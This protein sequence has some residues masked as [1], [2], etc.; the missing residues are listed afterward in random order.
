MKRNLGVKNKMKKNKKLILLI[1][2]VILISGLIYWR[3][4]SVRKQQQKDIRTVTIKR[5]TLKEE[6]T[7]TG[8]IEALKSVDVKSEVSGKIISLKVDE[9][10]YV[11]KGDLIAQLD[12]T[13]AQLDYRKAESNYLTAKA[14]LER[15]KVLFEKEFVPRG[16]LETAENNFKQAESDYLSAKERL[17]KTSIYAPMSGQVIKKYLEEGN[18]IASGVS[19]VSSGNNIF[20]IADVTHKYVDTQVDEVDIG[21]IKE[22]TPAVI[23]V[24]AYPNKDFTGKVIRVS[25]MATIEQ[26]LTFFNVKV[27]ILDPL[28]LLRVNMSADVKIIPRKKE[29]ALALPLEAL[30]GKKNDYYV[31]VKRNPKKFERQ[32]IKIGI[33]NDKYVEVVEG[34]KENDEILVKEPTTSASTTSSPFGMRPPRR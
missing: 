9:G 28:N 21:N 2:L 31:L 24:D 27:E 16:Q 29:N 23:S 32:P 13:E 17:D 14:N 10:D 12:S 19:L 11:K 34:L 15:Q 3:T 20:T 5:M 30:K 7:A 6:I 25:P 18:V 8:R 22:G 4:A 1:A 26:N 33:E